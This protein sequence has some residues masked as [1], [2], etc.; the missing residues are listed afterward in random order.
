MDFEGNSGRRPRLIIFCGLPGSGKTTIARQE[1]K[2]TGAFRLN[3]DEWVAALG[4]DFWDDEFRHRLERRLYAHCL[5]LLK[6][7]HS[8]IFEDGTWTRAERAELRDVAHR[9]GA[10]IEIPLFDVPYA[11]LWRRLERRNA[12]GAPDTVPITEEILTSCWHRFE[13]PDEAELALF[14][15]CAVHT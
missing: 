13:R 7:G 5:T 9:L 11:E 15:R 2:A 10:S 3:L 4:V 14:D 6:L 8:I 1:E 12:A